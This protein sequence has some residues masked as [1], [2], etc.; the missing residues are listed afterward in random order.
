MRIKCAPSYWGFAAL[1][2]SRRRDVRH[3]YR[4]MHMYTH[5]CGSWKTCAHIN[6][7]ST[8]PSNHGICFSFPCLH[9]CYS[10]L[11]E[12]TSSHFSQYMYLLL[13]S[14]Y[15][16]H[17]LTP[18]GCCHIQSPSCVG[19]N[20]MV[21]SPNSA[22]YQNQRG[23]HPFLVRPDSYLATTELC[24]LLNCDFFED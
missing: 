24:C 18:W 6:T 2:S 16:N 9:A 17:L 13:N 14:P 10:L 3:T 1:R 19:P 20:P 15:I 4:Y 21:P 11:S 12:K 5:V 23:H 8:S 22:A 7:S